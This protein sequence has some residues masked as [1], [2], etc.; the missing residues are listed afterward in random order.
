M[1]AYVINLARSPER[2]AKVTANLDRCGVDYEIVTAIDAQEF[3]SGDLRAAGR[4]AAAFYHKFRPGEAGCALSHMSVYRKI[5]ADGLERALVLEDD[6]IAPPELAAIADA[7]GGC[8]D[9]AEV[10]L[11][12]F[13]SQEVVQVSRAGA[14]DLPATRQL[15]A[16]LHV[17]QPESGAAYVI[18]REACARM[19]ERAFPIQ[20]KADDWAHFIQIGSIDRLRC[21]VPLAV[22]K[23]PGFGSTMGYYSHSSFKGR[24]LALID[25]LGLGLVQRVIAYRRERIWRRYTRVEFV[26]DPGPSLPSSRRGLAS[27]H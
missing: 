19:T 14:I 20:T 2:R 9:G 1:H 25:R 12:N 18:T 10:A 17:R 23:H 3:G 21:V 27:I 8:L 15:V 24:A 4:V 11:L 5:L 6:I 13:D 16:P 7:V 22:R 26:D